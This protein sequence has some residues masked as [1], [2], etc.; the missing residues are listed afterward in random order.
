MP[1]INETIIPLIRNYSPDI[2]FCSGKVSYFHIAVARLVKKY[3]PDVHISFTR[4]SS[5]YFSLNKIEGYLKSN[6]LLFTVVDSIILEY[7][8]E[9]EPRLLECLQSNGD[10]SRLANIMTASTEGRVPKRKSP[11]KHPPLINRRKKQAA[12]FNISPERI[13]DIHFEPNVK[14]YWNKCAFCGINKKY[15]HEDALP[16]EVAIRSRIEELCTRLPDDSYLWFID[17][18]ILP[19]KLDK[20]AEIFLAD[21]RR[22]VW[23]ARCRIDSGLLAKG[24]PEKLAQSGLKE[25]RLGLESGSLSVLKLMNKFDDTFNFE[26]VEKIVSAYSDCGIAVHFPMIIG[27]PGEVELDRHKTY[28][29]L[30]EIQDRHPSVSFNINVFNLDVASPIFQQWDKHAISEVTLPCQPADFVGNSASWDGPT[31]VGHGL[32]DKERNSFMRDRLY[33]WMPSDTLITPAIFYRFSETIRNTLVWQ[34]EQPLK[35]K[36]DFNNMVV[37]L[38]H[39]LVKH[40]KQDGEYLFYNWDTHH[41]FEG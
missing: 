22:F 33:S 38:S 1:F 12:E 36:R 21:N 34:Q 6:D 13:Y 17:E 26:L 20:I 31:K 41:Y 32:L 3:L 5:E 15:S 25:F 10:V 39:G 27:F 29:F 40:R 9:S 14:C 11:G 24:L 18:A 28:N 2:I 35:R 4:H 30:A 8:D 23:Q 7:F 19:S 16:D 37:Q